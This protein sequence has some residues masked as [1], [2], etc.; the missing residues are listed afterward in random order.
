VKLMEP[1]ESEH[2]KPFWD[3]TRDERLVIPHSA[4]HRP[5]VLVPT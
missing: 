3:A 1:P 5:A 4:I 2:G